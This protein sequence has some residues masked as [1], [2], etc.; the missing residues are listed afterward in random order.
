MVLSCGI[1]CSKRYLTFLLFPLFWLGQ[2]TFEF[3]YIDTIKTIKPLSFN[4]LLLA[5]II[6][7]SQLLSGFFELISVCFIKK[8]GQKFEEEKMK[9][10]KLL[11]RELR[12]NH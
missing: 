1:I 12:I 8:I 11:S 4:Y 9:S 5:L 2:K 10:A 3:I 6:Y 7:F